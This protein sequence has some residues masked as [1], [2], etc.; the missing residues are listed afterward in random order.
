MIYLIFSLSASAGIISDYYLNKHFKPKYYPFTA[1]LSLISFLILTLTFDNP[2][3]IVKG[4]IFCQSLILIGYC[5]EKTYEIPNFLLLP[6]IA[7]GFINFKPIECFAGL[8]SVSILFFVISAV[9]K[10]N[11]IGGGDVKL[12]GAAGFVL[13]TENVMIGTLIGLTL[14]LIF[15][16]IV[17]KKEE[18]HAMAPWLGTGC[19]IAYI[20]AL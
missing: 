7:C 14:F 18:T 10:G 17:H 8:F 19:I 13:G 6:I 5:D 12:I 15:H 20:T 11:G 2:I 3:D 4:F 16:F 1:L 9:T